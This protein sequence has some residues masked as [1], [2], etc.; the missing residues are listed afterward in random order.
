VV[1]HD[2]LFPKDG[3]PNQNEDKSPRKTLAPKK[4]ATDRKKKKDRRPSPDKTVKELDAVETV[5]MVPKPPRTLRTLLTCIPSP[6]ASLATKTSILM[7]AVAVCLTLLATFQAHVFHQKS[8]I[9]FA[10]VGFVSHE[11]AKIQVREP[12]ALQLP[13]TMFVREAA[14]KSTG[15]SS[16]FGIESG[17][18][19]SDS[20]TPW[21]TVASNNLFTAEHD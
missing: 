3:K 9:S 20:K 8:D 16:Y 5:R 21:T 18:T 13:V 12:R 19:S 6:N 11:Y 2:V 17:S 4:K 15:T 10:R 1:E 7:N 14:F